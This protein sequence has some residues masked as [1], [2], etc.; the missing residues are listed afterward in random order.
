VEGALPGEPSLP[1]ELTVG[2]QL[3]GPLFV[4]GLRLQESNSLNEHVLLCLERTPRPP[5]ESPRD[6]QA[7]ERDAPP[8]AL[9]AR[10]ESGSRPLWEMEAVLPASGEEM[11]ARALRPHR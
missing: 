3:I 9:H 2:R 7:W 6:E 5:P 10:G 4:H 8:L 1:V 11:L